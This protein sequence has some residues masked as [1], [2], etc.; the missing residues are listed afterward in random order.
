LLTEDAV[1]KIGWDS[2]LV[3]VAWVITVSLAV[4]PD[5]AATRA[6]SLHQW[7]VFAALLSPAL[8]PFLWQAAR[9]LRTYAGLLALLT[10][11]AVF[12][13]NALPTWM[14]RQVWFP[15]SSGYLAAF[16]MQSPKL[17]AA[18]VMMSVL[19]LLGYRRQEF[20]ISSG[21]HGKLSIGSGVF[22]A[23]VIAFTMLVYLQTTAAETP[24]AAGDVRYL[25]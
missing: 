21:A 20:F 12:F 19:A 15:D 23:M 24:E 25:P 22:V 10:F 13:W 2:Q 7:L 1:I 6:L 4:A 9:P 17:V 5:L 3:P 16:I 8:I 11:L 18:F 14:S